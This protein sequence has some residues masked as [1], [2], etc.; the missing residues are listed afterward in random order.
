M[1]EN[2]VSS[3]RIEGI[4]VDQSRIN[5]LILGKPL[6]N[7]RDEEEVRG[8]HDAL[9]LIHEKVGGI[10]VSEETILKFHKLSRGQIWDSGKYK[11]KSGD[12]M[13]LPQFNGHFRK[14]T[15]W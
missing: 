8:Y 5:T 1:I 10:S 3:N 9:R 2:T 15:K 7:D 13:N 6:L 11:R 14:Y 12:R 4:T